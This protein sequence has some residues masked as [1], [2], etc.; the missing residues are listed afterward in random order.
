MKD[1]SAVVSIDGEVV[2]RLKVSETVVSPMSII[3]SKTVFL[4]SPPSAFR[5]GF[6]VE[7]ANSFHFFHNLTPPKVSVP[8]ATHPIASGLRAI[9]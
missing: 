8:K 5:T 2:P 4:N 3:V 6:T 7:E 9:S 1:H